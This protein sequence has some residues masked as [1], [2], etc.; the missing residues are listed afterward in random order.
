MVWKLEIGFKDEETVTFRGSEPDIPLTVA[1]RYYDLF[2]KEAEGNAVYMQTADSAPVLL[3][4]K[5]LQLVENA[6]C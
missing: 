3:A 6:R 4:D 1:I 5:I 2:V